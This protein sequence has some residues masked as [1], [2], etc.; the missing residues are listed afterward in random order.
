M[1]VTQDV[2]Q[3]ILYTKCYAKHKSLKFIGFR[4]HSVLQNATEGIY[5][6]PPANNTDVSAQ[7]RKSEKKVIRE[8]KMASMIMV[9]YK[10]FLFNVSIIQHSGA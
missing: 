6:M 10:L 5:R 7:H 8:H 9:N 2:L 4:G 3:S 1:T